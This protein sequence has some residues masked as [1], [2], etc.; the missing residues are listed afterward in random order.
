MQLLERIYKFAHNKSCK[1]DHAQRRKP[2]L[3]KAIFGVLWLM[4]RSIYGRSATLN[5]SIGFQTQNLDV[6]I[7][8]NRESMESIH[9]EYF[10]VIRILIYNYLINL[11]TILRR[12][13]IE[14]SIMASGLCRTTVH[15]SKAIVIPPT[16]MRLRNLIWYNSL[17]GRRLVSYPSFEVWTWYTTENS[18]LHIKNI[19]LH[20]QP[21]R[22]WS[23][24]VLSQQH[25]ALVFF[26]LFP[27]LR[28]DF[29]FFSS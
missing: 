17:F 7:R 3:V 2:V 8:L 15:V 18:C 9:A 29:V 11:L 20:K 27:P 19:G 28:F 4:N 1:R 12:I 25:F 16:I 13:E 22:V 21:R 10:S 14:P 24:N 23:S 5:I 6:D 26:L